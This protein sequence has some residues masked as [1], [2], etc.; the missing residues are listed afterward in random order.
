MTRKEYILQLAEKEAISVIR[1]AS[2]RPNATEDDCKNYKD[3]DLVVYSIMCG[4]EIGLMK[5][6]D[7]L[8]YK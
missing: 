4:M 8:S 2:M 3:F 6:R 7:I 1:K 5:V